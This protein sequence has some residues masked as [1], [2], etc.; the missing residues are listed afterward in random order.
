MQEGA[1]NG[2]FD[3]ASFQTLFFF[4]DIKTGS[5]ETWPAVLKAL[6]PL[7][8][9]GWLST[10]D[11]VKFHENPVTVIGTGQTQL[12][13]VQSYLP[14]DVFYDAPL[15]ELHEPKYHDLT[16]S[17]SPIASTNFMASLGEV[18]TREFNATQLQK[19]RQQ[20]GVAGEKGI[21]T[22]YWNQPEY[23]IGT[24]NAVWRIL[25][26]EGVDLLSV[27]DLKAAAEFWEA[28]G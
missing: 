26:E 14:R 5:I 17:V 23:P 1:Q 10:F 13:D 24:R 28:G 21:K 15:A 27:D 20:V 12:S 22:R 8:S 2:V 3:T 7:R 11:G 6:E 19:L 25:W 16:A 18:R 9:G 4:I